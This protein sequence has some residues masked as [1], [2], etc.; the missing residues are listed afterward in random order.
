MDS[1]DIPLTVEAIELLA[2][3]QLK[4][5]CTAKTRRGLI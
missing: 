3:N 2:F 4:N 5:I 1:C